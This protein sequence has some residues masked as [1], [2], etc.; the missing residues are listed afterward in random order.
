MTIGQSIGLVK[1]T[2]KTTND[3]KESATITISFD[4]ST[5]SDVDLRNWLCSN[6]AIIM[7]RPLRD[8]S[9]N[10]I[11]ALDGTT[12]DASQCGKKVK[13][14]HDQFMTGIA[15]LRGAGM[16][17]LADKLLNEYRVKLEAAKAE[18]TE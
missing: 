14:V 8:L 5:C 7:Q 1:H 3:S 16:G 11:K 17:E 13:S 18:E 6:R 10:E 12:V 15:G 4:F 2:F 9:L